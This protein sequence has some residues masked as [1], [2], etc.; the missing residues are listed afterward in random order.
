MQIGWNKGQAGYDEITAACNEAKAAGMFVVSSS[1]EGV[2]GFRFHG[3]GRSPLADP[4]K[5]E[6]YEP[7]LFWAAEFGYSDPRIQEFYAK[8][9]MIPMDSRTLA[10]FTGAEDYFFCRSGGWSWSIPYLAGV[11]ALACQV[12][13]EITPERLL[14]VGA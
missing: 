3:L 9:L 13:P 11:Y 8:R 4:D 6:S 12:E 7:G 1:L 14:G 5:F 10:G 2:H